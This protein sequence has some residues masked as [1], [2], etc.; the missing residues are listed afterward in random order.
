MVYD[1]IIAKTTQ[2][3][4]G[5][6][7]ELRDYF[8]DEITCIKHLETMR[9]NNEPVCPYCNHKKI[10]KFKDK[11]T[12]KCAK[13]RKRFNVKVRTVFEDTKIS[14][15]KWFMAI[16]FITSHKKGISSLQLSKDIGVTQ[17][18]AWFML[19]RLRYV[20]NTKEFN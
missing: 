20:S 1:N 2:N 16:Y 7:M 11:K 14:L 13:C 9:W 4:F 8:S 18:T 17:K 5:N 15:Q 3:K 6:L 10:Y 19:H 12:Y